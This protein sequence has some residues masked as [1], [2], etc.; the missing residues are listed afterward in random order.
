MKEEI[1]KQA[2]HVREMKKEGRKKQASML[3]R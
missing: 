2:K 3:E 1:S